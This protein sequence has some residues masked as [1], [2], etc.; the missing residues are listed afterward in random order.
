MGRDRFPLKV[1]CEARS[2]VLWGELFPVRGIL[3]DY[4]RET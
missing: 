2:S 4:K 3:C 1:A